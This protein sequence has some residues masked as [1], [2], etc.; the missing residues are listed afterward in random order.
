MLRTGAGEQPYNDLEFYVFIRGNRWINE[1][2]Y[3]K[4]LHDLAL[5]LNRAAGVEI[6]FKIMSLACLR[7]SPVSMFYYDLLMGH[8]WLRGDDTL[9]A[10][11]EHHRN[12]RSIPLS[13]ATRLLM[14]RCSGL[15]F[16]REKLGHQPFTAEDADFVGRNLAKAR[17]AFGDAVLT[18]F[19]QYHWSCRERSERL[20][21]LRE[22]ESFFWWP[23][24]R[25]HHAAGIEF[26]LHPQP[27]AA[28]ASVLEA[29]LDE[30]TWL[31]L[32]LWLWLEERRLGS[33]FASARGYARSRIN[34]CPETNRWRN[35]LVNLKAFGPLAFFR[36]NPRRHPRERVLHALTWL[37]WDN[38]TADDSLRLQRL[39]S[40]LGST[41]GSFG[42]TVGAYQSLWQRFN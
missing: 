25:R 8:R 42:E 11:C 18:A 37:L 16:A 17:L 10:G 4:A 23:A 1:L 12:A 19:G 34:K 33:S 29:E 38:Q 27:T 14:N 41:P 21:R 5:D 24:V 35:C 26:K 15:L 20:R 32:H 2:R 30:L 36:A 7:N 31:G 6:E 13:E 9:L 40:E 22:V 3:R 39:K 28:A